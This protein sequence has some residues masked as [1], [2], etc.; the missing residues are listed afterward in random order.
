MKAIQILASSIEFEEKKYILDHFYLLLERI[1]KQEGTSFQSDHF[2]NT[3]DA[4]TML[5]TE[6]NSS[7]AME[8][9]SNSISEDQ[10]RFICASREFQFIDCTDEDNSLCIDGDN[11]LHKIIIKDTHS[12][13]SPLYPVI[14]YI[15]SSN[16]HSSGKKT[17]NVD[18]VHLL[19]VIL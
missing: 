11:S 4:Q 3:T 14:I 1:Y 10:I 2:S 17:F 6:S 7:D 16:K 13:P 12:P 5:V 15:K 18:F 19:F 9:H 8:K